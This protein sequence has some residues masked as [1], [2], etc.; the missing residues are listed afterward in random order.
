M[1]IY[2]VCIFNYVFMF[3]CFESSYVVWRNKKKV[4]HNNQENV[5]LSRALHAVCIW[6]LEVGKSQH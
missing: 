2:A 4:S 6:E 3:L 5:H 1:W